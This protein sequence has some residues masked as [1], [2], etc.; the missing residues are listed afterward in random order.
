MLPM[1]GEL[2]SEARLRGAFTSP[3]VAV[4]DT[5]PAKLGRMEVE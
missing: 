3:S 4:G 1:C 2:S 5:S